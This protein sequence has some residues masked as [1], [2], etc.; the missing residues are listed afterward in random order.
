MLALSFNNAISARIKGLKKQAVGWMNLISNSMQ[1]QM[2][3]AVNS[4][5]INFK[6]IVFEKF[7]SSHIL[8]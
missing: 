1:C 3:I 7:R 5:L 6:K 4:T 2:F 8:L